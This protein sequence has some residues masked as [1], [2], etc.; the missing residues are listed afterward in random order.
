MAGPVVAPAPVVEVPNA[1][2]CGPGEPAQ[3]RYRISWMQ[4]AVSNLR[5]T[6]LILRRMRGQIKSAM[7]VQGPDDGGI[8]DRPEIKSARASLVDFP[9]LEPIVDTLGGQGGHGHAAGTPG[10]STRKW[11]SLPAGAATAKS[12]PGLERSEVRQSARPLPRPSSLRIFHCEGPRT[13]QW[14]ATTPRLG[15]WS[16][17]LFSRPPCGPLDCCCRGASGSK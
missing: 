3:R 15:G 10:K 2:V 14:P 5:R 16:R 4:R 9:G 6:A 1:G 7:Q 13:G 12:V 11:P 17:G 8:P